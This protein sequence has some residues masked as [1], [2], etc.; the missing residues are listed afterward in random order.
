MTGVRLSLTPLA[1]NSQS[2]R[3]EVVHLMKQKMPRHHSSV[4][5][6]FFTMVLVTILTTQTNLCADQLC[7]ATAASP[8]NRWHAV[9]M[10]EM[11]A[12]LGMHIAMGIVNMPSLRDFWSSNPIMQ[13]QWFPSIMS[14]DRFKQILRY[15]HCAD[16]NNYVPRGEEGHDP[17]YK[18]REHIDILTDRFR[19]W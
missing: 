4:S 3:N 13:H 15:F 9:S 14:R 11:L 1:Q 17:L 18:V 7:T 6:Y 12:Y 10:E 5:S 8:S 2:F 19:L 16:S